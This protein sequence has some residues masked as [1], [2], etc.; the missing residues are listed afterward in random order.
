VL[1]F[2]LGS[3]YVG[4]R[5]A[6]SVV[7]VCDYPDTCWAKGQKL[8]TRHKPTPKM[9]LVHHRKITH[10]DAPDDLPSSDDFR[11][12]IATTTMSSR[13]PCQYCRRC[14]SKNT[15][16]LG[17]LM[18]RSTAADGPEVLA[19]CGTGLDFAHLSRGPPHGDVARMAR[20]YDE[21]VMAQDTWPELSG[22]RN[23]ALAAEG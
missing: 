8:T 13:M 1:L 18:A 5:L 16:A 19:G 23:R 17:A 4:G 9:E 11:K 12:K 2:L 3:V 14:A 20:G 7:P 15:Q 21:S 6:D 22:T 10:D